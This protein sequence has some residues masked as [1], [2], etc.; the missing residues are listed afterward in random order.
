MSYGLVL[1]RAWLHLGGALYWKLHYAGIIIV[2]PNPSI[3]VAQHISVYKLLQCRFWDSSMMPFTNYFDGKLPFTIYFLGLQLPVTWLS[4]IG[5]Y[6][7]HWNTLI[8]Q[9]CGNRDH[10]LHLIPKMAKTGGLKAIFDG[11]MPFT[12]YFFGTSARG[13][14]IAYHWPVLRSLEHAYWTKMWKWWPYF[15]TCYLKWP[16]WGF[17]RP[18]LTVKC[19]LPFIFWN[20]SSQ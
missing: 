9:K 5:Q 17:Y 8:W 13:N 2:T 20:S 12:I 1:L 19:H 7:G 14:L 18:F 15:Y 4:I 10:I 6:P 3:Y 11:K 16:K